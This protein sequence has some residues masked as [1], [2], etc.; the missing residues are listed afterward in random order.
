MHVYD[1]DPRLMRCHVIVYLRGGAFAA[2]KFDD[3]V[4]LTAQLEVDC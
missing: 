2:G 1:S 4:D 3:P